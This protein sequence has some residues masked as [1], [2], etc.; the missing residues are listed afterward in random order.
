MI[1][2]MY[3]VFDSKTA[4]YSGPYFFRTEAECLR[5]FSRSAAIDE[6]SMFHLHGEDYTLFYTGEFNDSTG[7]VSMNSSF[8]SLGTMLSL[9]V[10]YLAH[11]KSLQ[12]DVSNTDKV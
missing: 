3:C 7:V 1:L 4:L 11:V 12:P 8:V 9:G 6:Q 5:A 10:A 2:R